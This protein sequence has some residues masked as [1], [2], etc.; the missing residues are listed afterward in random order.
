MCRPV[1]Y[2]LVLFCLTRRVL[3]LRLVVVVVGGVRSDVVDVV[4]SCWDFAIGGRRLVAVVFSGC[5]YF[6]DGVFSSCRD[7][8]EFWGRG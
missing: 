1:F 6:V 7:F 5:R 8:A 4:S 2:L 3:G